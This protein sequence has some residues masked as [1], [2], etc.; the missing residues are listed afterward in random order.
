MSFPSLAREKKFRIWLKTLKLGLKMPWV[1]SKSLRKN[2]D[3][4]FQGNLRRKKFESMKELTTL[5]SNRW[6]YVN[7]KNRTPTFLARLFKMK[8]WYLLKLKKRLNICVHIK[9]IYVK[10]YFILIFSR[11]RSS[12]QKENKKI[13]IEGVGENTQYFA[14]VFRW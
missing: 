14:E 5:P 13:F 7:S 10:W 2:Q 9:T 6:Q 4:K 3:P 1:L 12:F 8:T 11:V